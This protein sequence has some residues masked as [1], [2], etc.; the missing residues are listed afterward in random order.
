MRCVKYTTALVY[1]MIAIICSTHC[2]CVL[3]VRKKFL[4]FLPVRWCEKVENH[5][6]TSFTLAVMFTITA[7]SFSKLFVIKK[8]SYYQ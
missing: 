1:K 5:W 8:N 4:R 3:L 7:S 2:D 6:F